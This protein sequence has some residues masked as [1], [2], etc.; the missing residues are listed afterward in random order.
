MVWRHQQ[1]E[2]SYGGVAHDRYLGGLNIRSLT[3]LNK[4]SDLKICWELKTSNESWAT[5]LKAQVL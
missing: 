2:F 1:E 4:A 5:I 3:T